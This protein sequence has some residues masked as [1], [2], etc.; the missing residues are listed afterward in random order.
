MKVSRHAWISARACPC[1]VIGFTGLDI[2]LALEQQPVDDELDL[3]K[4]AYL[5]IEAGGRIQALRGHI[6]SLAGQEIVL[7]LSDDIRLGQRRI[8]SR[9]PISLP[10]VVQVPRRA[11]GRR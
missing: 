3:E 8:F 2:V 11:S 5:L 6:G 1:R 10:A 9:A 7:R 4:P